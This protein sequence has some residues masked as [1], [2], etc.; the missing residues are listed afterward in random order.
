VSAYEPITESAVHIDLTTRYAESTAIVASPALA[1]ETIVA[2]VTIPNNAQ[3]I[4]GVKVHGWVAFTAGTSGVSANLRVRQTSTSG[5]TVVTSGAVTVVAAN[6]YTLS[7]VGFDTAP[8][9][10]QIYKL[11]LTIGSGAAQS[12]DSAVFLDAIPY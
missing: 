6:L 3:V 8:A 7:V 11:T 12:T 2:S 1:A 10:G 4:Q 9:Q 5:A